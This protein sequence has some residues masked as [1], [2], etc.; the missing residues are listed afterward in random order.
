MSDPAVSAAQAPALTAVPRV[1][2]GFDIHPFSADP[3]RVLVLGG[4][5]IPGHP[6]LSGHSDADVISH[7]VSDALLGAAG[8]GDLGT[9][10]PASDPAL[11]GADSLQ[12]LAQ[13]VQRVGAAYLIG[14][15]DATV[16]CEKP[17]LAG[18]ISEIERTLAGTVGA[19]VSVKPKRAE[20]LGALGRAE[21]IGCL[22]VALLVAHPTPQPG[23][24]SS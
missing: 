17:R 4:V 7:A 23:G 8:M 2:Q 22:A 11:S 18:H 1:G 15:V 20:T 24:A 10:F 12:L 6:G 14:N 16:I 3:A 5:S 19:P 13:V 21:G 9:M